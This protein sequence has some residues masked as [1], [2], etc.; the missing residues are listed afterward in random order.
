MSLRQ[1]H[2]SATEPGIEATQET[3]AEP[4][5]PSCVSSADVVI[6]GGGPSG[7][8]AAGLLH[9]HG[10]ST[11]VLE[12]IPDTY[13]FDLSRTYSFGLNTRGQTAVAQVPGLSSYLDQ[14]KASPRPYKTAII[15]LEGE[16]KKYEMAELF[17]GVKPGLLFM[18]PRFVEA[19][20][21]FVKDK[22]PSADFRYNA[23]V[24]A[25]DFASSGNMT[26]SYAVDDEIATIN[27][28][29]ILACDGANSTVREVLREACANS[30]AAQFIQSS[31]GFTTVQKKGA[32][33]GLMAG[34]I[35][36]S[37]SIFEGISNAP[38][39]LDIY[40]VTVRG[41]VL[42]LMILPLRETDLERCGGVLGYFTA[43]PDATIWNLRD[44]EHAYEYL[45]ENFPQLD[46]R[47]VFSEDS[48]ARFTRS[49]RLIHPPVTKL[50]S[51]VARV[52][53]GDSGNEGGVFVLGD[54]AHHMP[55]D[56]GQ[57]LNSSLEDV[58]ELIYALTQLSED[59]SVHKCL[60]AYEAHRID[61]VKGL[62]EIASFTVRVPGVLSRLQIV[63]RY[64]DSLSRVK[65][66]AWFPSLF[67]PS[68]SAMFAKGWP[69]GLIYRR[70]RQTTLRLL[71]LV[72]VLVCLTVLAIW[73][74]LSFFQ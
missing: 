19:C 34:S 74:A 62:C 41:R 2:V 43:Y 1:R 20:Q 25:I 13:Q 64:V 24:T 8:L 4:R 52:G 44:T 54:A 65:M 66:A 10:V 40:W 5:L 71:A 35:V 22:C 48:L 68:I 18:R 31:N 45:Q 57:G 42:S 70:H 11:T 3:A 46:V 36:L 60:T 23:R 61:D 72:G 30:S 56:L 7:C 47:K 15:S 39:A 17:P 49:R 29:L 9:K 50:P 38:E 32:A 73:K 67:Y 63:R 69:Y 53:T 55:P 27:T 37:T 58:K 51:L 21:S 12:R 26:V 14:V 59:S 33:T 28:R 6:V 16:T